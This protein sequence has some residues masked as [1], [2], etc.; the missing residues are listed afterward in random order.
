MRVSSISI[1][2]IARIVS[3]KPA[4]V[5]AILKN[6]FYYGKMYVKKYDKKYP[7]KYKR[8]ITKELFDKCQNIKS[9]RAKS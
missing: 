6:P 9:L 1:A 4:M 8:L 7:H 5:L 2:D 3:L